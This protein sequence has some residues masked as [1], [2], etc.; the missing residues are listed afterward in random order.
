MYTHLHFYE[1]LETVLSWD[2]SDH[3]FPFAMSDQIKL[4]A[5]FEV[6]EPWID[7]FI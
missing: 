1:A 4:L 7:N 5:G 3:L 2:L 6:E